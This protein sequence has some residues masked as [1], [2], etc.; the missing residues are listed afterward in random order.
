[1][2]YTTLSFDAIKDFTPVATVSSTPL[3]LV[4]N[5]D[6]PTKTVADLSQRIQSNPDKFFYGSSGNGTIIHL[7]SAMMN[8]AHGHNMEHVPYE[9]SAALVTS[10]MSGDIEHALSSM[11]PAISQVQAGK[12]RPLAV[13]TPERIAIMAD[14]PTMREANI[15]DAE[16]T[17]YSGILAPAG[18]PDEV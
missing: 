10:V 6:S 17:L 9:R 13:T 16:V 3:L 1:S 15:P 14:V 7:A 18:L 12:L 2:L 5:A 11:P 8:R 4:V